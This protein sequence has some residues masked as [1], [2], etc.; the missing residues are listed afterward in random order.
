MGEGDP[1]DMG[2]PIHWQLWRW[3]AKSCIEQQSWVYIKEWEPVKLNE[4]ECNIISRFG[5]F[6]I[7]NKFF[8]L[9]IDK[10][11]PKDLYKYNLLKKVCTEG[12]EDIISESTEGVLMK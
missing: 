3:V 4:N 12:Y 8:N 2:M 7:N 1:D 10:K 11:N 5:L 9:N 6:C